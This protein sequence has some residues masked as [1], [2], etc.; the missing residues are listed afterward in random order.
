MGISKRLAVVL[1][2]AALAGGAALTLGAAPAGAAVSSPASAPATGQAL[3][4]HIFS[5]GCWSDCWDDCDD[6]DWDW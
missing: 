5:C 4:A 2:G 1:S 3:I 6:D